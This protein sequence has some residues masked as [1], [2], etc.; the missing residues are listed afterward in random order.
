[1]ITHQL[2]ICNLLYHIN[3]MPVNPGRPENAGFY[4]LFYGGHP[5]SICGII[6][7]RHPHSLSFIRKERTHIPHINPQR[8]ADSLQHIHADRLVPG[9]LTVGALTDPRQ[10]DDVA[11][12]VST[13]L[14][15]EPEPGIG[16]HVSHLP[17]YVF[18]PAVLRPGQHQLLPVGQQ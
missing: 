13:P 2:V 9:H 14:Q 16:D 4:S 1:M 10:A 7:I 11:G 6:R 3:I 17:L 8:S 12:T 15:E 18:H 5:Y